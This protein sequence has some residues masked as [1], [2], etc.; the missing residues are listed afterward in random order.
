[1]KNK[2]SVYFLVLLFGLAISYYAI[3]AK[4]DSKSIGGLLFFV[5]FIPTLVRP[6]IGLIVL[7]IS[8]LFSPEVIIGET[9]RRDVTIR[10][11]DIFLFIIIFAWFIRTAFTKN[12]SEVFRTKL[13]TPFF[14]YIG[15][16]VASSIFAAV[17]KENLD[18]QNSFL[19]ILKYAEYF[20]LF[21][22]VKENLRTLKQAKIFMAIFLITACLVAIVSNVYV[23]EQ[24][25]L[26][27]EFFRAAGPMQENKDEPGTLGGYFV[28][29]MAIS[30]GILIYT[31]NT[32]AKVFL[33]I[34]L[35]IMY[36]GF[37]YSLSRGSYLAFVPMV[38]ALIHFSKKSKVLIMWI[39]FC[40]AIFILIFVP[41][42][43]KDRVIGTIELVEEERGY[44]VVWEE[45][46][47]ARISSW[48]LVLFDIIPRGPF[49]G[50]GVGAVFIDSQFFTTVTESGLIGL[51]LFVTVL[52]RLYQMAREVSNMALVQKDE[53]SMG[54]TV[55][56][57]AG[58]VGLLFHSIGSNTFIIIRVMEPFWF[59]AAVVI[60]LPQLLVR[61]K[62]AL[63]DDAIEDGSV[64]FKLKS[65]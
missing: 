61:E 29:L 11:E 22:M 43:V 8:M 44:R 16:C 53:F 40:M 57:L 46:P 49:M 62:V 51:A 3:N 30:A 28:F 12:V 23:Y 36:R 56:F 42:M 41:K 59:L 17:T 65:V 50:H 20:L 7:I 47:Q 24:Q 58:F 48:E 27:T 32:Y 37:L 31:K 18:I 60:A 5:I 21:L 45:S 64:F 10:V 38:L 13:S 63:H 14:S 39:V 55:G 2:L 19:S 26:G 35:L 4:F 33:V 25:T 34:L 54:L 15:L 9:F 6:D 52:V 1:M